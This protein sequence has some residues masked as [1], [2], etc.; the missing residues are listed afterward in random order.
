MIERFAKRHHIPPSE[1]LLIDDNRA[2][3]Q[4]HVLKHGGIP[5]PSFLTFPKGGNGLTLSEIS[6]LIEW[7]KADSSCKILTT[8]KRTPTEIYTPTHKY[9]YDKKSGLFYESTS[10][11]YFDPKL[12]SHYYYKENSGLYMDPISGIKHIPKMGYFG[13]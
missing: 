2:L 5:M 8:P 1:V 3:V 9:F 12:N 11:C 10:N 7:I 13:Y 4:S 6:Q